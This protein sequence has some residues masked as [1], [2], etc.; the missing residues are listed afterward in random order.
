MS[1][2]TTPVFYYGYT[3][4]V[5]DIYLNFNEGGPELTALITAGTYSFSLLANEIAL[6]MNGVGGQVYTVT[7]NRD[8]RTYTISA[9]SNFS[10]FF[11][12]GANAGLSIASVIGFSDA[13]LSGTNSYTGNPAGS[14]FIPQFPLQNYVALEDFQ[15]AAQ[16]SI[17]ESASGNVEVYSIGTRK[18]TEFNIGPTTDNPMRKGG[19]ITNDSGAV[20]KLRSFISFCTT[21]SP[22]EFM[23][24]QNSKSSFST[25]ILET[26]PTSSTGTGFKLKELYGRGLVGFFETGRLKFRE[27]T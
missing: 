15:E 27:R 6:K 21:K 22:I 19:L 13:D 26:T 9:D 2:F 20:G 17:N 3:V 8:T 4:T 11:D 12:T 25:L 14:E 10:I 7:A 24:D 1:I 23:P 18:F 5:N 16:A